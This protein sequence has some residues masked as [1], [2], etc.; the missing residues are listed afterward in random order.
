MCRKHRGVLEQLLTPVA[1]S[2]ARPDPTPQSFLL[3]ERL[4]WKAVDAASGAPHLTRHKSC[5]ITVAVDRTCL[6]P[7]PEC[8]TLSVQRLGANEGTAAGS[9]G[10][11]RRWRP[12][13]PLRSRLSSS[14]EGHVPKPRASRPNGS[15][16]W[17]EPE[18]RHTAGDSGSEGPAIATGCLREVKEAKGRCLRRAQC[19]ACFLFMV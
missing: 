7:C 1:Q 4:D 18:P 2:E 8:H 5:A 17:A 6:R 11:A 12:R 9:P 10:E 19:V 15:L 14:P 13:H 3:S 16:G